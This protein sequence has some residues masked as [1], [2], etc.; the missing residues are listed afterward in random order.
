[1]HKSTATYEAL[2]ASLHMQ[3]MWRKDR[4]ITGW[5]ALPED[6][7]ELIVAKVPLVYAARAAAT[8]KVFHATFRRLL[9]QE[10]Q[11][12]CKLAAECFGQQRID[13]LIRLI[14]RMVKGYGLQRLHRLATN[15][16]YAHRWIC[17]NGTLRDN[18]LNTQLRHAGEC[19]VDF[20]MRADRGRLPYL[21]LINAVTRNGSHV[22]LRIWQNRWA[23]NSIVPHAS[24][25]HRQRAGSYVSVYPSEGS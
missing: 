13:Y 20:Q 6:L 7:H 3:S 12:R 14:D 1:M 24:W 22:D 9:A 8:C 21:L 11:A 15:P 23:A 10:L 18:G 25:V 5:N 2:K 19:A 17:D 16:V 4:H